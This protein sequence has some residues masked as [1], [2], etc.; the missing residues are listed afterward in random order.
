MNLT[1]LAT[2]AVGAP[3]RVLTQ[4]FAEQSG[5]HVHVQVDTS[6]NITRRLAAGE[7]ADILIAQTTTVDQLIAE[8]RAFADSR[9]PIGK[10]GVGVA[11]S[12][13]G[14]RPDISTAEALK[15]ALLQADAVVCSGGASGVHV[16]QM[17][18]DI[19][20]A[21]RIST[22]TVRLPSGAAVMERLGTSLGNEIGFTMVSE[23]RLGE[24]HG[25]SLVGP[26]P[27]AFQRYTV[28]DAV[29]MSG[30][31]APDTARAF[32]RVIGA[33]PARQTFAASGWEF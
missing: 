31:Q 24:A 17:L 3:L 22:T 5:H 25:G 9:A 10:I 6:P 30:S 4:A 18:R 8:S 29:V 11:I 14:V 12:R 27:T 15:A 23:I 21:D 32:V 13:G 33:P 16:E 2:M 7:I 28:Y 19:G 20:I 1:A 26:L